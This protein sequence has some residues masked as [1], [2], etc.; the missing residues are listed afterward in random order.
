MIPRHSLPFGIRKVLS[1]LV[2]ATPDISVPDLEKACA[3]LLGV[4]A[5]ILLPSVRAGIRMVVQAAGGPGMIV[6]GPAYTC[7]TVHQAMALSSAGVRLVDPAAGSFLMS[8][9]AVYAA[10]EPG[11]AL[12]FSEV[13]GIPYG[14]E[15]LRTA[16]RKGPCVRILDMAMSVP[17]LERTRRLEARDVALFS[18]G[19]GKPL[20]AGWGGIACFQ[21]LELAGRVRE[22]RD[23][24]TAPES[25]GLRFQRGCSTL[26]QVAMNQRRVYG[27][28][29]EQHIYR[30]FKNAASPRK[31]RVPLPMT[32]GDVL[33]PLPERSGRR[34]SPEWTRP[35]TALN[36]DLALHNLRNAVRNADLRRAQ[37]AIYSQCLVEPGLVQGLGSETL[38]QSHFPIRL[39]SALRDAM[40]DYLRGRGIDTGTLF[41]LPAGL[42]RDQYPHAAGAADEVVTLPLGPGLTVEEVRM[43]SRRV[44]EGLSSLG[45]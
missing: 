27:L 37:A 23:R 11:C 17:V 28:F 43:I 7:D 18:F 32:Q 29:H 13:Y 12:V 19:W 14:R 5:A 8:P 16:S 9:D 20:Y 2:S 10:S 21:D 30:R 45:F 15:M 26:L 40:C 25:T 24:G 44:Q 3:D 1:V 6:A 4:R 42:G 22:L 38:P 31:E 41:P 33:H 36:R 35:M 39:P 34:L